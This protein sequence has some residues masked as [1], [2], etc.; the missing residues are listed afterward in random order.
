AN[1][2]LRPHEPLRHGRGGHEER[3]RNLV[4]LEAAQRA[5]GERDL[6]LERQRRM[7]AGE[8]EAKAIVGNLVRVVRLRH[9]LAEA[10]RGVRVQ[11]RVEPCPA[12]D[13]AD[14]LVPGRLDDPGPRE[15]WDTVGPL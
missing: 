10:G 4:R 14:S 2:A 15:V 5:E 7:A 11:L 13:A 6:G 8:D 1:L 12:P 9:R 3:A